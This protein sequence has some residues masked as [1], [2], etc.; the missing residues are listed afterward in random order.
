MMASPTTSS[1]QDFKS[2]LQNAESAKDYEQKL[3]ELRKEEES[4]RA[5]F[6]PEEDTAR[7]G[8]KRE[9]M[10]NL[11]LAQKAEADRK[12]RE[13]KQDSLDARNSVLDHW[14]PIK[15]PR[16]GA[17]SFTVVRAENLG[18][19]FAAA[20]L[21]TNPYVVVSYGR[22]VE[23]ESPVVRNDECPEFDFEAY[24]AV[25][26]DTK[27]VV[28]T[29]ME[30]AVSSRL[31]VGIVIGT[32]AVHLRGDYPNLAKS[33]PD[34]VYTEKCSVV[35]PLYNAGGGRLKDSRITI[36]W[37][38]ELRDVNRVVTCDECG[39]LESRC[40]CTD[41]EKAARRVARAQEAQFQQLQVLNARAIRELQETEVIERDKVYEDY[42]HEF[43]ML[44]RECDVD[45][46]RI[47]IELR[48]RRLD[49]RKGGAGAAVAAGG[50]VGAAAVLV[51]EEPEPAPK[52]REPV[53][54]MQRDD[55]NKRGTPEPV[56][57]D[58]GRGEKEKKDGCCIVA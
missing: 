50:A 35:Q 22:N 32:T 53:D 34:G 47:N 45:A 33:A 40:T 27:P 1:Q 55:L 11:R 17:V 25:E 10:R 44:Q 49:A 58:G 26:D 30:R 41:E 4:T 2:A 37:S 7:R 15:G 24:F 56:Y 29:I 57:V 38:F 16:C 12:R 23:I 9:A 14:A 46:R 5:T 54:I 28:V 18:G 8:L 31:G 3:F 48:Q 43:N 20:M 52:P 42:N 13:A 36:Q 19:F 39:R 51:E 21:H 6:D